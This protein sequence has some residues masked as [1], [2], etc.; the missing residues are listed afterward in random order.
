MHNHLNK[1]VSNERPG[2]NISGVGPKGPSEVQDGFLVL[3]AQRKIVPNNNARF[4][5]KSVKREHLRK[6]KVNEHSIISRLGLD[7]AEATREEQLEVKPGAPVLRV[8]P[9]C[10]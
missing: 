5:S 6:R 10:P 3:A 4:W 9:A 7:E 8:H 1:L 2:S